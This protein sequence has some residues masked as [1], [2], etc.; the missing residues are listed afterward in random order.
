[1]FKYCFCFL[2]VVLVKPDPV[3][4]LGRLTLILNKLRNT[5]DLMCF[6]NSWW[7][8]LNYFNYL[9]VK[10]LWALLQIDIEIATLV[11]IE[12]WHIKLTF[13]FDFLIHRSTIEPSLF[14]EIS[15]FL[16]KWISANLWIIEIKIFSLNLT[17]VLLL[18]KRLVQKIVVCSD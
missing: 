15:F 17:S 16:I 3:H 5:A 18:N 7:W 8:W 1:M 11:L 10:H 4:I 13:A 12:A 6:M 2:S 9:I 14:K